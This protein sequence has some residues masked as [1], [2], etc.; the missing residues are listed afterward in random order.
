M[1]TKTITI[2]FVTTL[3]LFQSCK[4]KADNEEL[5]KSVYLTE[6]A[7]E[8]MAADSGIA[9]AFR[10]FADENAVIVRDNDSI[11]EGKSKIY[12]YYNTE[13]IKKATVNWTPI[14]IEVSDDGTLAYTYGKYIWKI[15]HSND[16]VTTLN[17]VFHTVWKRQ[18]DKK[19]KYVWD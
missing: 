10:N 7:F 13:K 14:K 1:N 17:G 12:K 4:Q 3:L 18:H 5:I 2:I 9:I 19:W 16:S 15:N 8:K 11:I 6:K